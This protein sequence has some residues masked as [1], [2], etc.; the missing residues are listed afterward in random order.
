M[1]RRGFTLIELLVVIAVIGI[2]IGLLLPAVQGVLA[3]ASRTQ[4]ANNLKQI[5]LALHVYH[6]T[7]AT[8]VRYRQCPNWL[9]DSTSP[10]GGNPDPNC[11][12]LGTTRVNNAPLGTTGTTTFT[13]T[14]EVWWAPYDNST[15]SP[16]VGVGSSSG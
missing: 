3:A 7:V 5:G 12:S 2:L 9:D 13:G 4:C 15:G 1:R 11:Q 14:G 10:P 16:F 6:D 8:I